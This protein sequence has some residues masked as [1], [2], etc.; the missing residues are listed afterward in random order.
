MEQI[1]NLDDVDICKWIL[2][3]VTTVYRPITLKELTSF[4]DVLEATSDDL[5]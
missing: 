2:A 4:N 1:C 3:C 5:E